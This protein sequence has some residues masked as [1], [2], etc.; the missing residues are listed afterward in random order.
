MLQKIRLGGCN[1]TD[2]F[3]YEFFRKNSQDGK[4]GGWTNTQPILTGP[5]LGIDFCQPYNS[6][7]Q[8]AS[9][10]TKPNVVTIL[11]IITF[12]YRPQFNNFKLAL[13]ELCN[14]ILTPLNKNICLIINFITL[15]KLFCTFFL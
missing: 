12:T 1:N 9:R 13:Q 6:K 7:K 5:K 4:L 8:Y 14:K 2:S 15:Y 11:H 3:S 10:R